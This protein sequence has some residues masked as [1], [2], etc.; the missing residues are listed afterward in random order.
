MNFF[1]LPGN[2]L[3]DRAWDAL[4]RF[5]RSTVD[6]HGN[7]ASLTPAFFAEIR[8]THSDRLLAVLAYQGGEPIAGTIN[9]V[10][11]K[12]MY[13][14][15]WGSASH[16]PMLHFELCFYRLI[17]H[18][19]AHRLG[20]FEGG[21]GGEQKLARGLLPQRTYSTHWIRHRGLAHAIGD[22]IAREAKAVEAEMR[23]CLAHSPFARLRPSL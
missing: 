2:E 6:R 10:R 21:A 23:A 15:Y 13:G 18:A 17:E 1:T 22:Y 4:D 9:F 20:T 7:V 16:L 3:D 8:R 19:I 11:G 12:T 14:R 5:Y